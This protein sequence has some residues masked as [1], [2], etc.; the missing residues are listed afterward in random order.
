MRRRLSQLIFFTRDST[1]RTIVYVYI[2]GIYFS[3]DKKTAPKSRKRYPLEQPKVH[4]HLETFV[5]LK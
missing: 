3:Q 4:R 1:I 2:L 5:K